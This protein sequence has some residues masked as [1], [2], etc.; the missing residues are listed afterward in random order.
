MARSWGPRRKSGEAAEG[1]PGGGW[2]M[3]VVATRRHWSLLGPRRVGL[4]GIGVRVSTSV[5]G[6]T[7][8]R[9]PHRQ[10]RGALSRLD[11]RLPGELSSEEQ[12]GFA[13]ESGFPFPHD[14]L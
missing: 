6:L 5:A 14:S 13:F 12:E 7:K 9:G 10:F 4:Q 11:V 3:G 2:A 1:A 8:A